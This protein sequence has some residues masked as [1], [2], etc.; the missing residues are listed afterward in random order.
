MRAYN[1]WRVDATPPHSRIGGGSGGRHL[2]LP[3]IN[4][5]DEA[6]D[7]AEGNICQ[8]RDESDMTEWSTNGLWHVFLKE[9]DISCSYSRVYLFASVALHQA[10]FNKNNQ[11]GCS[12]Q[13]WLEGALSTMPHIGRTAHAGF[14]SAK[15]HRAPNTP[16]TC[17]VGSPHVCY[18]WSDMHS[19]W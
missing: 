17:F 14:Q 11:F 1:H 13:V 6:K 16:F 10:W 5:R 8:W 3:A 7:V 15:T 12:K 18:L 2:D 19:L 9:H 4:D